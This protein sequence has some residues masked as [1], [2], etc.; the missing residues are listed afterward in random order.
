LLQASARHFVVAALG[1]LVL[2][3]I[4]ITC[5]V[6]MWRFKPEETLQNNIPK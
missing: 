6:Q 4:H 1:L 2:A 3:E 5:G